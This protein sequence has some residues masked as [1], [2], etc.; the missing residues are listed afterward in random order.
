MKKHTLTQK[1]ITAYHHH[2][3]AEERAAATIEKY[4]RD[5]RAFA[6]WLDGSAVTKALSSGWKEH[7]LAQG[8]SPATVN[9]KLSAINGLFRFLG[10]EDCRV[11]FLKV[12]RQTFR[13]TAKELTRR[14]YNRLI[15]AAQASGKAWLALAMQTMGA[16]GI[17][18][19]ELGCVTVEAARRGQMHVALKGKV[20]TVMLP[21]KLC[22]KLLKYA[23]KQ[24]IASGK[25]FLTKGGKDIPRNQVWREMKALCKKAGV[26]AAK[27]FPHNLR[28]LFAVTFYEAT[29]DLVKLADVMG[30]SSVNTTRIYLLTTG[31]EHLQ[32]LN[33]LNMVC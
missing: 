23:G 6:A 14:E 2:L 9:A 30:H 4:T 26:E 3:R 1:N 22:R 25:I 24:K 11:K 27:V 17:R 13:D 8:L 10:L 7:L 28:H 12:Q 20:R 18:V 5:I 31:R 33:R 16:A 29:R 15:E 32:Q 21:D 19:S